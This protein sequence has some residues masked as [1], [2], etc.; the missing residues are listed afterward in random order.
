MS[1]NRQRF[2]RS[3]T[4]KRKKNNAKDWITPIIRCHF[5]DDW[6]YINDFNGQRL[7]SVRKRVFCRKPNGAAAHAD[8]YDFGYCFLYLYTKTKLLANRQVGFAYSKGGGWCY[9][10]KWLF[11]KPLF[12]ASRGCLGLNPYR[13]PFCGC[14]FSPVFT[15]KKRLPLLDDGD[16]GFYRG[17]SC[18]AAWG[19]HF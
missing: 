6:W 14:A 8:D 13:Y 15:G 7:G 1:D 3:Y 17:Y 4:I 10:Y 12:V 19:K 5:M 16:F 9:G 18:D 11:P 2:L